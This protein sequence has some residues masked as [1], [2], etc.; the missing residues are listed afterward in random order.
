MTNKSGG[1]AGKKLMIPNIF[2]TQLF[3]S[4]KLLK[5]L[6]ELIAIHNNN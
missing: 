1:K 6:I 3:T 2:R 5:H 4:H